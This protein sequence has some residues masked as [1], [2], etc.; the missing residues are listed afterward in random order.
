MNMTIAWI[1]ARGLLGRRR[2]LLLLPMPI[3]LIGVTGFTMDQVLSWLHGIF[4]PWT[5]KTDPLSRGV[6]KVLKWP[7]TALAAISSRKSEIQP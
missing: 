6:I 2:S 4:F 5:G 1:T 7:V 3:I